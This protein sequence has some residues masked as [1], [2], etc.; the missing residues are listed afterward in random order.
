VPMAVDVR[1]AQFAVAGDAVVTG[2]VTSPGGESGAVQWRSDANGRFAATVRAAVPG[3]YRVRAEARR[4]GTVLGAA[5]RWMDI[6]GV[7]REFVDPRLNEAWLRRIARASGGRYVRP[8][9]ASRIVGWLQETNPEQGAP[10]RRD[11]WHEPL[12][13]AV[14]ITLLSAEWMLRRRWGLR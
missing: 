4:G 11:L 9:D 7:D 1:D 12:A 6:G 8:S 3:L 13:F 14:I 10:E 5:E 2:E